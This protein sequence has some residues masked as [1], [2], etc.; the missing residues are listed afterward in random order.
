M[1]VLQAVAGDTII[2]RRVSLGVTSGMEATSRVSP[3][4]TGWLCKGMAIVRHFG[5]SGSS[6]AISG[7]WQELGGGKGRS[8]VRVGQKRK[9]RLYESGTKVHHFA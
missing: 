6:F 1:A 2:E 8:G 9:G 4:D 3:R 7:A 5:G